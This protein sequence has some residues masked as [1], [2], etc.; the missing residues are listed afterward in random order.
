MSRN[1]ALIALLGLSAS[2]STL[3]AQSALKYRDAS[4]QWIYTDQTGS[5]TAHAGE[6]LELGGREP[7]SRHIAVERIETAGTTQLMATNGCL[8]VVV[9]RLSVE[10]SDLTEITRGALYNATLDP[11]E[12][13]V[14]VQAN[15]DAGA[16]PRLRFHWA[17]SL[18]SPQAVHQP[19]RPYRAPFALGATFIVSQAYPAHVTHVT[20]DSRYAVDIALPDGTPIYAA[21]GGTVI[22]VRHDAFIGAIDPALLDQANEVEILHPD[23]TIAVYA[24]LHWDSIQVHIGQHVVRGEYLANSGNTGFTSG[25]HLHFAVWRNVG[26]SDISVPVEFSGSGDTAVTPTTGQPLTAY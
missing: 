26:G 22:D 9:V 10:E 15:H 19:D 11:G 25:P 20:A 17:A 16:R 24:H 7:Q 21:R 1:L 8:C 14:L 23:G 2:G 4:G 5:A 6:S 18:G 3:L 13:R 12:K